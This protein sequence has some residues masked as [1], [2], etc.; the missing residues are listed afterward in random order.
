MANEAA[1]CCAALLFLVLIVYSPF[2]CAQTPKHANT[3]N[4]I[5]R[6]NAK[7]VKRIVVKTP[8]WRF[9]MGATTFA[10]KI[11]EYNTILLCN[12]L[13]VIHYGISMFQ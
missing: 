9:V 3:V 2:P 6:K 12:L 7:R 10:R 1:Y 4:Q 11:H 8:V 5:T 13:P